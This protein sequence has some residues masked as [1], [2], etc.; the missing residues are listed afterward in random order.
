MLWWILTYIDMNQ[1]WVH[2]SPH[3]SG[4]SQGTG[5]ESPASCIELALVIDFTYGN[6]VHVSMLFSQIT[7]P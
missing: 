3:P 5:F 6:N 2:V 7:P 1:P 4:L